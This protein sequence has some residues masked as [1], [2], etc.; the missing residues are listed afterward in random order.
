MAG[1]RQPRKKKA[2][3]AAADELRRPAEES[4]GA[5]TRYDADAVAAGEQVFEWGFVFEP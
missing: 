5:R 3:A 4:D 1:P 2:A